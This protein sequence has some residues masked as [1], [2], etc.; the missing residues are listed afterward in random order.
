MSRRARSRTSS[1]ATRPCAGSLSLARQAGTATVCPWS[2][3]SSRSW[4]VRELFDRAEIDL[5]R[6]TA[7]RDRELDQQAYGRND[8]EGGSVRLSLWNHPGD[9][10]YGMFS[11]NQRIVDRVEQILGDEPYHYHSK[12]IMKEA[13]TGGAWAWHQDY[14]YWYDNGVLFP[15]LCSVFIAVDP[16]T[17]ANGCLQVLRGS[18]AHGPDQSRENGRSNGRRSGARG[19]RGRAAGAGVRR[20]E[21]GRRAVLS[22]QPVASQRSESFAGRSLGARLLLQRA[23]QRPVQGGSASAV[24]AAERALPAIRFVPPRK[25]CGNSDVGDKLAVQRPAH[26][27]FAAR[28]A[29]R[30]DDLRSGAWHSVCEYA[31]RAAKA[32]RIGSRPQ[33]VGAIEINREA[34]SRSDG[35]SQLRNSCGD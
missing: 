29:N 33:L 13:R 7:K 34:S 5:L 6:D 3:R 16:A 26:F 10:L 27:R 17:R 14:G 25:R 11:R 35:T 22:S 28:L 1:L 9:D 31:S 4:V 15:N 24:Y 20:N 32:A 8:G 12:M 30:C 21:P 23:E 19:R 2:S 18:H